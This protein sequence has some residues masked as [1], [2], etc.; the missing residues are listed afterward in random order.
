MPAPGPKDGH[1][2]QSSRDLNKNVG[3]KSNGFKF[4]G[5]SAEVGKERHPATVILTPGSF[6]PCS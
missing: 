5:G 3:V 2:S 1:M 6:T 4:G